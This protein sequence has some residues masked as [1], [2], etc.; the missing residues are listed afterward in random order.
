MTDLTIIY[1]TAN[2]ISDYFMANTQKQLLKAIGDTPIISVSQKPIDFGDNICVGNIGRSTY[3]IYKQILIGAREVKTEYVATAEDDVLY[4]K[5]HFDYRPAQDIFA[6]DVNKWSLY[7]WDPSHF[8]YRN[9]R[10]MTSLIVTRDALVKTLEQRFTKYPDSNH[11]PI[12]R[13]CE[14]GRYDRDIHVDPVQ[15]ER[16]ESTVPSIVFYTSEAMGFDYLG[17]RKR[18]GNVRAVELSPWGT[19]PDIF[20]L[21]QPPKQ[22][23]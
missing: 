22:E 20:K 14:P 3:N 5:E 7:T 16:Y 10:T 17:T 21:Y 8:S 2:H 12:Q 4:S 23:S 9:R 11:Y 18:R 13:W 1:Y 6:Y 15:N 19:A